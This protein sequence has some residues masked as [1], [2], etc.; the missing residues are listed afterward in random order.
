MNIIRFYNMVVYKIEKAD[1]IPI[2]SSVNLD[3][4]EITKEN[5]NKV[6]GLRGKHFVNEF[7]KVLKENKSFGLA[8]YNEDEIVGYGWLKFKGARDSFFNLSSINGYLSAFFVKKE[9][10]GNKI[11]PS[12]ITKLIESD[13]AKDI[14][15]FYI[16]TENKNLSSQKG[17][18]KL[19]AKHIKDVKI[20]RA[21][22]ITWNKYKL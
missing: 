12:L 16:A 2:E 3:Y 17:F 19:N 14:K 10:R 21:M 7:Q 15:E 20:L 9:Y 5:I 8:A 4:K 18:Q 1:F 6:M 13:K 11:Y 22:K